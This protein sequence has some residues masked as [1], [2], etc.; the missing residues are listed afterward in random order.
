MESTDCLIWLYLHSTVM[1]SSPPK[2]S[3]RS[4]TVE[5]M[6]SSAISID[7]C[8][9][10]TKCPMFTTFVSVFDLTYSTALAIPLRDDKIAV[11]V[12]FVS[13][14]S[15]VDSAGSLTLTVCLTTSRFS[16]SPTRGS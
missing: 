9:Y 11:C 10:F 5:V 1:P 3:R 16:S 4:L 13:P 8:T 7:D 14:N 15:H 6:L 2:L 12:A